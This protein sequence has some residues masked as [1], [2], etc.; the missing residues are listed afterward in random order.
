[1]RSALIVID[2]PAG[3]HLARMFEAEKQALVERLVAHPAV[4]ALAEAVLHRF[5]RRDEMPDDLVVPRPAEHDVRGELGSVVRDDHAGSAALLDQRRQFARHAPAG[6]RGVGDRRQALPRHVIHDVQDPEAATAGELVVDEIQGPAG[7]D[8]R[9]DQ[10]RR[11]RSH[12]APSRSPP[13]DGAGGPNSRFSAAA[14]AHGA[15]PDFCLIF[16]R[17]GHD[18]PEIL[19]T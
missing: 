14:R 19:P 3:D 6:D 9:L 7:V 11:T 18:D 5:A 16:V 10:D 15:T 12:G 8:R 13:H 2:D 1:M 17:C 4:E